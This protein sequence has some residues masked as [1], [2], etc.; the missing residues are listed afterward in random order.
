MAGPICKVKFVLMYDAI[1]DTAFWVIPSLANIMRRCCPGV[2]EIYE[3][4]ECYPHYLGM[5]GN[6]PVLMFSER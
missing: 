1:T 5:A 4:D 3:L 2:V 6:P